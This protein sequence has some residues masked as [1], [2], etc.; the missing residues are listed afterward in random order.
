[1]HLRSGLVAVALVVSSCGTPEQPQPKLDCWLALNNPGFTRKVASRYPAT[2][3]LFS[4]QQ[5]LTWQVEGPVP[6]GL[7]LDSATLTGTPTTAGE[8]VLT[9]HLASPTDACN[10]T[11][12]VFHVTVVTPQCEDKVACQARPFADGSCASSSDCAPVGGHMVGCF[13]AAVG[14]AFCLTSANSFECGSGTSYEFVTLMDGSGLFTCLDVAD[15][16]VCNQ[17]LCS[18]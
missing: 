3:E 14:V 6:P 13:R 16:F 15:T 5:T 18:P 17:E 2:L 12:A 10:A 4:P 9:F 11:D 7:T 1:M 8:Y